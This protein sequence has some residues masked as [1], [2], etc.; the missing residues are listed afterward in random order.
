M[1]CIVVSFFYFTDFGGRFL[2]ASPNA[3]VLIMGSNFFRQTSCICCILCDVRLEYVNLFVCLG[4]GPFF[5]YG[6]IIAKLLVS[7]KLYLL[8]MFF[9]FP[10]LKH[11]LHKLDDFL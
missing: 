7:S 11:A 5:F 3:D 6:R 8:L 4:D 9:L 1:R 2:V 10:L